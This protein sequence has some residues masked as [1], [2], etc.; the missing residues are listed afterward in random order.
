MIG[1]VIVS[2][3][4]KIADGV[5]ELARQVASIPIPLA[6]S[7]GTKDG[8]LGTDAESIVCCINEVF[9]E[10]GVIILFDLGSALMSAEMALEFLNDDKR[11]KV[12]IADAPLVEGSIIAAVEA[13]LGKNM[14]EIITTLAELK[15]QPKLSS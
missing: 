10:D 6:V 1:I 12:L 14:E 5:E 13:T 15:L 2:H 3:S 7:G 11:N 9:S 4:K 8:R